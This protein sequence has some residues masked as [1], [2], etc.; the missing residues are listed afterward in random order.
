VDWK[1]V[2]VIAIAGAAGMIFDSFLGATWEN[3]GRMGNNAVN[4]VSTVF[5]A[6]IALLTG[7][8]VQRSAR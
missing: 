3:A 6:D 4:F 1:W 8:I 5:A 7:L 2:P